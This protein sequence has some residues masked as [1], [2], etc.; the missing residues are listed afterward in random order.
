M[1]FELRE[2]NSGVCDCQGDGGD[3]DHPRL[4]LVNVLLDVYHDCDNLHSVENQELG[5]VLHQGIAPTADHLRNT[6]DRA[7]ENGDKGNTRGANVESK[8]RG[9]AS[10]R[11][12]EVG[13]CLTRSVAA[14]EEV[15]SDE[16]ANSHGSD[17]DAD[18]SNHDRVSGLDQ[19]DLLASGDT[20]SS[21]LNENTGCIGGD[22]DPGVEAGLQS[23]IL[24]AKVDD[25]MLNR[26]VDSSGEEGGR[27]NKTDD[28]NLEAC[29]APG[30]IVHDQSSD[31]TDTFSKTSNDNSKGEALQASLDSKEE[32]G[33]E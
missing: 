1:L 16:T 26:E 27:Q 32:L 14:E 2:E 24:R 13:L 33:E 29:L 19:L 23:G 12:I 15:G 5:L 10:H 3:A 22:E 21:S 30:V 28:L 18:T 11:V 31:V 6:V 8:A 9:G 20:T 25:Q 4:V 17:L 7:N